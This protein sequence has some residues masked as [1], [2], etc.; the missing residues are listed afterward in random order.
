MSLELDDINI[1][2]PDEVIGTVQRAEELLREAGDNTPLRQDA[3]QAVLGMLHRQN[4]IIRKAEE[5]KQIAKLFGYKTAQIEKFLKNYSITQLPPQDED[6]P[7]PSWANPEKL[8]GDGF[9]QLAI[10]E[11]GF[12][13]GIYFNGT[14][15]RLKRVSNFTI[16]PLIHIMDQRNNRRIIE[17]CNGKKTSRVEVPGRALVAKGLFEATIIERGSYLCEG[18]SETQFKRIV[19]WLTDEMPVCYDLVSLGWQADGK[20]FFAFANKVWY[21][22]EM[23]EFSPLGVVEVGEAHYISMGVSNIN[24]DFRKTDNPY[25]NDRYLMCVEKKKQEDEVHFEQWSSQFLKVYGTDNGTIGIAFVFLSLF[26]DIVVNITKCPH[27]YPYGPKGS[28]KSDFAES[29]TWLFNL[30]V[31]SI[32]LPIEALSSFVIPFFILLV[33]FAN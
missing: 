30:L 26:K 20:G 12:K 11:K 28:G 5:M 16:H 6:A 25:E 32:K 19:G 18:M 13:P 3:L 7:L 29:L 10:G 24:N 22:G 23:R 33:Y 27:L 17:I 4:N 8:Y 2:A 1:G 31:S 9:I 14:E 21:N 15:H